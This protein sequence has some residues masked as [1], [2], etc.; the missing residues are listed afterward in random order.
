MAKLSDVVAGQ[1]LHAPEAFYYIGL[2]S[3]PKGYE[4]VFTELFEGLQKHFPHIRKIGVTREHHIASKCKDR[5]DRVI[6]GDLYE[7]AYQGLLHLPRPFRW[8][9]TNF[10]EAHSIQELCRNITRGGL[11]LT[12][13]DSDLFTVD[14]RKFYLAQVASLE[15]VADVHVYDRET[16]EGKL[17]PYYAALVQPY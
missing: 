16:K 15:D 8:K 13:I 3:K 9:H 17:V 6:V 4:E 1:L 7:T 5:F 10:D 11:L 2:H 12:D 14:S